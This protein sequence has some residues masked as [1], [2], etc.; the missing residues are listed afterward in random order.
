MSLL[1]ALLLGIIQGITE[2]FPISS[3]A[4]LKIFKKLLSIPESAGSLFFDLS[5]HAGT[6]LTLIFFFRNQIWNIL[7]SPKT[8]GLFSLSLSPLI[9]GY[10]LL[11]PLREALSDPQYLGYFLFVTAFILFACAKCK[12]GSC[13]I[14]ER[15]KIQHVLWIGI[16]Q[17]M[18]LIP[19]ISRSGSTIAMAR[20]C[21]W[22]LPVAAEFSFL[23]AIPTVV[24]GE[25]LEIFKIMKEPKAGNLEISIDCLLIGFISSFLVGLFTC[26][27]IFWIY[28]KEIIRPFAW[29]CLAAGCVA[30]AIFHG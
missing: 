24:G 15:K 10:F 23:L 12:D 17:T 7:K 9:P 20:F 21:G 4:H 28:N 25:L 29:Y 16:A 5:C 2:F 18:A 13:A 8:I 1:E 19:G 6:V 22:K 3:S 11:K 30:L 26:R 27:A 14:I